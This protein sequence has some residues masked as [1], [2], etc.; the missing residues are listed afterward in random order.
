MPVARI[1]ALGSFL[2][3]A[4]GTFQSLYVRI[5]TIDLPGLRAAWTELPYRKLPGLRRMLLEVDRRTPDGAR[6][7][8]WLPQHEW[9][10]GYG[11]GFWR[12]EYLLARKT[13]I[14]LLHP[15]HDRME[16]S[17]LSE[18]DWVVCWRQCPPPPDFVLTW[19][20][21]DGSLWRRVR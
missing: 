14:P 6:I 15:E 19:K 21:D 7:L 11:Y 3:I 16:P 1:A 13:V 18:A 5:Y 20:S 2:A 12:A 8:L 9:D 17:H 10:G 4:I